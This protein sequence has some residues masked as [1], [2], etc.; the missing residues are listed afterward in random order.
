MTN[1]SLP[2]SAAAD[3]NKTPILEVLQRWLPARARVLEIAS[4]TGQHAAHFAAAHPAWT[5]QPTEANAE[6]LPPIA[7]RCALFAN[8]L[9]PQP[10]DV[11]APSW[12]VP[13]DFDAG[14]C[15]NLLHIAP[16]EVCG[17]LMRGM[18]RHLTAKGQLCLYG[19]FIVND[20]PTAPSNL[21]FD[22]DLKARDPAW[23]LRRLE[24]VQAEAERAGLALRERV[25]M[26]ANNLLV[27]FE[28]HAP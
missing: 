6:W 24:D 2:F 3:R 11:M 15:A 8:V 22:A 25:E 14:Y 9:A 23:G 19:P 28:R 13:A 7:Q 20:R 4:G 16:W 17:A 18:A 1:T 21:A 10:L 26:P 12:G 5:W 27:L